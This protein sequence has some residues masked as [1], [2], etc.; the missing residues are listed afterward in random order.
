M[1]AIIETYLR[2]INSKNEKKKLYCA[3]IDYQKAFDLVDRSCLWAKL[4]ACNIKGKIMKLIFNLYQN[5]KACVKLNNKVSQSFSCN[6]GVRQGDNLSPLL[7][8][9]FIND[10][11][12]YLSEKFNGLNSLNNIY[13]NIAGNEEIL[14]LLKLYVLLYADDT[15]IMAEGPHELQLAL[16]ALSEYCQTYKLKINIDKTKIIRFSKG[17]PTKH[18]QVFWLNGEVVE[19]VDSYIY[20][21]TTINFNGKFTDAIE[22]QINQAHRRLFVI[23]S[24]KEKFNLPIDI[25]LDLFDKMIL[26]ILLYGSEIWGFENLESIEIFYRKFLK[27]ILKVNSQTTDEMVY[28]ETGRTPLHVSIKTRMVCFWHKIITGLN[29]KLSYRLLYLLNKLKEQNRYSSPWLKKVQEILESC[30]M[31][32]IWQNPKSIKPNHLRKSLTKQLTNKY[33]LKWLS[34]METKSSCRVYRTFKTEFKLERYLMLPD[35]VDRINISKFRCRNSKIPVV[36]MR[37][38]VIQTLYEDRICPSCNIG[39]IGD[40]F[41]Y[42]MQCPVFQIQRQR[43]LGTP[44]LINPDREKFLSLLQNNNF[45]TLRKLAKLITE[46][47]AYFK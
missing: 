17:K 34:E 29:T 7:F 10:F 31:T 23:K 35:C 22:K 24:K 39:A 13:T 45:N 43:C 30:N 8:A 28:G 44:Y 21:G 46:I 42:I 14:T 47:N 25:V 16:N 20:L 36:T 1:H 37:Y 12:K 9:I 6:I 40:E 26:P 32:N 2:Q 11:E 3:F 4:L 18:I 15:I 5:T 33:K 27:Y 41:H 38:G 19:L